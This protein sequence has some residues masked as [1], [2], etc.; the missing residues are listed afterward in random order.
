[1]SNAP[2]KTI[3]KSSTNNTKVWLEVTTLNILPGEEVLIEL[4]NN[5]ETKEIQK[6]EKKI[7]LSSYVDHSGK[8]SV[9]LSSDVPNENITS[10]Q[11]TGASQQIAIT[12]IDEAKYIKE[13]WWSID[14]AGEKPITRAVPG[15]LVYFHVN[16]TILD[17]EVVHIELYEDDNNEKEETGTGDKD[18]HQPL[19]SSVTKEPSTHETVTDGKLVKS[20]RLDNLDGLIKNDVNKQIKLYFRCSYNDEHVE[21]PTTPKDY[22][23][24]GT[25][26]IDRYKMPGL[27]ASGTDIADDLTYGTGNPQ[28]EIIYTAQQLIA[29]KDAYAVSGFNE[30]KHGIFINKEGLY[31]K[32]PDIQRLQ[33]EEGITTADNN[34]ASLLTEKN[35][36]E[37]DKTYVTTQNRIDPYLLV[38]QNAIELLVNQK[39]K[40]NKKEMYAVKTSSD[41]ESGK[42]LKDFH[43]GK[44]PLTGKWRD[45]DS[46]FWNFKNTAELYFARGELQTNLDGMIEK[47]KSNTGGIY[48]NDILTKYVNNHP[49]TDEYCL[50]IEDYL[51][52]RLK[53]EFET[54]IGEIEDKQPY[55]LYE[56]GEK[57]E[58]KNSKGNRKNVDKDFS[59]PKYSYDKGYWDAT[60]GL[61]IA[62]NDIWATE[63]ILTQLKN[64]EENYTIKY[65]ITL[66]D[67]FGLDL[68]DMR[69]R[70]NSYFSVKEAFICWFVLQHLR[71]YK[72][73]VTKMTFEREFK[74][75]L[76]TGKSER[77]KQRET[78][79]LQRKIAAKRMEELR[80]IG[81][82][83]P[84]EM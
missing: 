5:D 47:F 35:K 23:V 34:K 12:N 4:E 69:K 22:L 13:G 81:R 39:A 40:Y 44:S 50:A 68:P 61:T 66:W 56:V 10:D 76:N 31:P 25:L 43:E 20:I 72:P 82:R 58:F 84:G 62:L 38:R 11:N 83:K 46:L 79:A 2:D 1:M 32:L 18:E 49:N 74:G 63:V 65:Q 3:E 28:K 33:E 6:G 73:F 15:M 57:P 36:I 64:K 7:K 75:N 52:E 78:E 24:V 59:K 41:Y 70:F 27:N 42:D 45:D 51:A 48:E 67:H 54:N 37:I 53:Q 80:Q 19:V 26:V 14:A 21:L 60:K 30:E 71:G 16:T 8:S 55:F 29:Y 17:G 77:I 9:L